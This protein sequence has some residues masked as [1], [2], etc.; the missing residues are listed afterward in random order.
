MKRRD[1]LKTLRKLAAEQGLEIEVTEGGSHSKLKAGGWQ[2]V[3]PRHREIEER[4]SKA[5]IRR[6][7]QYFKAQQ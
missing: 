2:D 7:E 4:L 3:I 6:A 5:I 1:L